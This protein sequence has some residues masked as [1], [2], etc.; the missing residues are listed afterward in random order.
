MEKYSRAVRLAEIEKNDWSLNISRYVDTEEE[1]ERTDVGVAVRR[2]RELARERAD[3]EAT[4]N[5]LLEEL[6][7]G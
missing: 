2:L 7:I 3:A 1:E 6:G 4:M 5:R